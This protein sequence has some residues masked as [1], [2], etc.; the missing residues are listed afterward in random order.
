MTEL[1]ETLR[2]L[3]EENIAKIYRRH[4]ATGEVLGVKYSEMGKLQKKHLGD[5]AL[6]QKLWKS[7]VH[8]A[9]IL[10]T[11]IADPLKTNQK[12]ID[13]WLKDLDGYPL[14]DAFAVFVARTRFAEPSMKAWMKS[15]EEWTASAGWRL[16]GA[17]AQPTEAANDRDDAFFEPFLQ[18]IQERIH[19]EPNRVRHTMNSALIAIGAR[20]GALEKK[21]LQAAK[22]IGVVHVDHGETDCETP[23]AAS[24]IARIKARAAKKGTKAGG[25]S[26]AKR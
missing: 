11:Q 1:I 2:K 24:Y 14:T 17:A 3:G 23:D 13:G 15:T 9:R 10:A 4:G 8:E 22:A 16:L 18:T 19:W 5:H 12:E 20:G 6:A 21:A 7:G 25:K 26:A